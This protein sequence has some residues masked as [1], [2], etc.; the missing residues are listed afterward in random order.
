M[1]TLKKLL[2]GIIF[3]AALL[4]NP[5]LAQTNPHF[6]QGQVLTPAQWNNLFASKQDVLGYTPM[7]VAGGTFSGR[8][9]TA[10]PGASTA[11]FNLT[12]GT[13][14]ASPIN[15]DQWCTTAG[16]FARI[17]G[18]TVDLINAACP[19]CA[20]TNATNT[21]LDTQIINRNSSGADAIQ[22]GTVLQAS[23]G[24]GAVARIEADSYA[25]ASH[26]T[27]VR[28]N[29]TKAS[30]T[31]LVANNEIVSLN[32]FGFD[33]ATR[34]GPAGA[35]RIFSAATWSNTSHP[36]FI[37][38]ATTLIGSTTLTSR[39]H[40]ENDGGL[41]WPSTVTG[42][43][44]GSGT[45]NAAG[46][47]VNGIAVAGGS[48]LL[49]NSF[50]GSDI[51]AQINA[52]EAA[53]PATGGT[54]VLLSNNYTGIA[55]QPV[56]S[57]RTFLDL[58]NSTL[59][60]NAGV[61]GPI[62]LNAAQFSVIA[63]G[64]L[65]GSDTSAGSNN[66]LTIQCAFFRGAQLQVG[67]Q[68]AVSGF[69]GHSVAV[70]S[71]AAS[72]PTGAIADNW[73]LDNVLG[74]HSYGDS[75]HIEGSDSNK[76]TCTNCIAQTWGGSFGLFDNSTEGNTYV[77]FNADGTSAHTTTA[78]QLLGGSTKLWNAQCETPGN[79]ANVTGTGIWFDN[80]VTAPCVVTPPSNGIVSGPVGGGAGG[81]YGLIGTLIN[82]G[83]FNNGTIGGATGFSL[84]NPTS[85]FN[86]VIANTE[87]GNTA[88][89]VLTI[90]INNASR[91]LSLGGNL[92]TAGNF[93]MSGA[94]PFTGTLTG[95][96]NVTF[97]TSGTLATTGGSVAS[98]SAGTTGL[99][100]NSAT[101]GAI[102][103]AGTLVVANGGT[104]CSAASITCFNNITGLSAAGTTGTTST[105]LVFSASPTFTGTLTAATIGA[106]T[107]NAFTAAG[108]ISMGSNNISGAG[109]ITATS[110]N[111]NTLTTGTYT[112]TGAAG[113]TLTFNNS[114]TISGTD[115]T[116][117]TFPSTSAT[118]AR[119]DAGQTFTGTQVFGTISPTTVNAFT[120]GG[121]IAG[122]GN[123]I[124]NVIIGTST[125]LAGTFTTLGSGV[126]TI[127]SAS[128]SA[129]AVG[130]NG[131]TNPAFLI[132]ASPASQAA[133]LKVTGAVT[134][135]TVAIAAIDSGSS[136]NVTIN[137]KG[138]GTI[139]IG[140]V[141][142][143]A[144]TITPATTFTNGLTIA[145]G[146]N[147]TLAPGLGVIDIGGGTTIF[148]ST[149]DGGLNLTSQSG[150]VTAPSLS[151]SAQIFM[152]SITT[153]SAAQTGTV[154]WTTGTGKFTVD[155]T[156]GCL[157]SIMAAKNIT[158][159][160]A[161]G[162]AL[163]IVSRLNPFAFRYKPG[164]GDSGH[165]EQFGF[166]AEE[167][168][169]VDERLVGRD[170]KGILSGVRYQEMTAVLAG[171]IQK[172]KT[173]NDNLRS[174]IDAMKNVGRRQ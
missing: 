95:T 4:P 171:A 146:Q 54:I 25:A 49:A 66:G 132:D 17:N 173:D 120:L 131:A 87:A 22:A 156:V 88:Q 70:L 7:N 119:T 75:F 108:T 1:Q 111:G 115:T 62:C 167:V 14:P 157:T 16:L 26:F 141:S 31:T 34:A 18:A 55:T 158:E 82:G 165:Y 112:L 135:G 170:P 47:Y 64:F 104:N 8:I 56:I 86:L 130:L 128:A 99:T 147:L 46:L 154:C 40:V 162:K 151:L 102:T 138:S 149:V 159:H 144:V 124:N 20:V 98:F 74:R 51:G 72:T 160:L 44:Q 39:G 139:G 43:S 19:V 29:G 123:Q 155:T 21:F 121:T 5:A 172:L 52:A 71:G 13:A 57:K 84:A 33:G 83:A 92:S 100:P 142:T 168:M 125:P 140:S 30:P 85:G 134:G 3:A 174:E 117:M 15:G 28:A 36:T 145:V 153:S 127:T 150:T 37:D 65:L 63:N 107:I 110:Y 59:L 42:G 50:A 58:N 6:T 38:F 23:Q 77:S 12:C 9:V 79:T 161:P 69:G 81:A 136:A 97:P 35:V 93:T 2:A 118:I 152:P 41:T 24:N 73:Q 137:A 105:N 116:T 106:T 169:L 27:G 94:F 60:F 11:G 109:A 133:G 10:A 96:T 89:R 76:G 53:L 78:Y 80:D 48:Y 163:D 91:T 45:I 68:G 113:K 164:Y 126:H 101:T 61:A 114:I 129:L 143:G 166:G 103:L 32:G 90:A 122:G 148:R 67:N